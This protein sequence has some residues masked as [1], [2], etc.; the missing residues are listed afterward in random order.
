[1]GTGGYNLA[2]TRAGCWEGIPAP[3]WLLL[4]SWGLAQDPHDPCL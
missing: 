1:M 3:T 2:W 4:A